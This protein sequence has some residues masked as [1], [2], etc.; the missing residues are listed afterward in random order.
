MKID[1]IQIPVKDIF[2]GYRNDPET[3]EVAGFGGKLNIRPAYQR[4][5]V[6][7]SE[8]QQEVLKSVVQGFPLNVMYWVRNED[9]TYELL[10]GQQRTLSLC[11][12]LNGDYSF[13]AD[14]V[15]Y[16]K[17]PF[18]EHTSDDIKK[19]IED[20]KLM[21]Y[22]CEGSDK[23]VLDWFKVANTQGEKLNDQERRNAMHTGA[24]L[25]DAKQFFSKTGCV[26]QNLGGNYMTGTPIRQDYLQTVLEW[27]ASAEGISIEDYM[28]IHKK[29]DDAEELKNYFKD[30]I[31]WI[32]SVFPNYR[33][34]LMPKVHWGLLYN[35]YKDNKYD[36]DEFEKEI[37]RLLA[38]EYI[39]N[40]AGIY[41]YLLSGKTN[42]KV[43]NIRKFN[44]KQILKMYERQH[45]ECPICKLKGRSIVD[46]K[47][48][49][50]D[51]HWEINEMDADHIVPWSKGGPTTVENGQ[52]LCKRHNLEKSDK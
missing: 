37:A 43:L 44:D 48:T 5:F 21:I 14:P 40:P 18:Y 20:Y 1:L 46:K 45:G 19:K 41:E 49:A 28:G 27:K 36:A 12:W 35:Q 33:K 16:P 30:I 11:R 10:D 25:S 2:D 4:E 34:K 47:H 23:E 52:M 26:A 42:E 13:F 17:T 6:Y 9:D 22:V 31:K 15:N 7:N 39:D 38:D 32:K 3:G 51:A 24:W 8:Q 50:D 29:D